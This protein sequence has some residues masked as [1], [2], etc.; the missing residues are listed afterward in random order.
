MVFEHPWTLS[1]R[2]QGLGKCIELC[3]RIDKA[4]GV[5]L[6]WGQFMAV[7]NHGFDCHGVI[8]QLQVNLKLEFPES[9][10]LVGD[11]H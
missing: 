2:R 5:T 8:R 7:V 10:A 1:G 6:G 3:L 9:T 4:D 11:S